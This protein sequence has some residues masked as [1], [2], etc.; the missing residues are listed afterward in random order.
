MIKLDITI[1]NSSVLEATR[2]ITKTNSNLVHEASCYQDHQ[3]S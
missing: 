3:Y 1:S 2:V